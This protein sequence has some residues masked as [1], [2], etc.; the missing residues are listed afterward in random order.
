MAAQPELQQPFLNHM[1]DVVCLSLAETMQND[2]IAV[3][4]K[5][6]Q[7]KTPGKPGVQRIV[8]EEIRQQR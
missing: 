8:Q 2:V 4:L 1:A 7:R 5:L 6:Y 3:P